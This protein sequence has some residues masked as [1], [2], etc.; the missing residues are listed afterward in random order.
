MIFILSYVPC[1]Y[2]VHDSTMQ[3]TMQIPSAANSSLD[4]HPSLLSYSLKCTT[5]FYSPL[6]ELSRKLREGVYKLLLKR[7]Y[8]ALP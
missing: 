4:P 6:F 1:T 3:P 5:L 8:I 7:H 2:N